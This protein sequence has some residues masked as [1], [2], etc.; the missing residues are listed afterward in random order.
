MVALKPFT[1]RDLAIRGLIPN[2]C[3]EEAPGSYGCPEPGSGEGGGY[4]VVQQPLTPTLG[5]M[6]PLLLAH[7]GLATTPVPDPVGTYRGAAF[8]WLVYEFES[9]VASDAG[10]V[11]VK[12]SLALAAGDSRYYMVGLGADSPDYTANQAQYRAIFYHML[13][14]LAP[15]E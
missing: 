11:P 7:S 6:S 1:Q 12:V 13:Y 2:G 8:D 10:P 5:V 4:R 9:S 15:L 14:A 3:R